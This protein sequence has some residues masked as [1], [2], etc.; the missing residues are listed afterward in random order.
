MSFISTE[1]YKNVSSIKF[2]LCSPEYIHS[3]S[4]VGITEIGLYKNKV[5]KKNGCNDLRMGT[6][7]RSLVCATCNQSS[8]NCPGH[9]G[10]I[11]FCEPI[12]NP[13]QVK[14]VFKV[15]RSVCFW[16]SSLLVDENKRPG[17][18]CN[19]R[20]RKILTVMSNMGKTVKV[21]PVCS[22][23]QPDYVRKVY[24]ITHSFPQPDTAFESPEEKNKASEPLTTK[25]IRD[26]LRNIKDEDIK[27]IGMCP[28]NS[29]PEWMV[30]T[31]ML[32]PPPCIRPSVLVSAGTQTRGEDF[33]T[34]KLQ[35]IVKFNRAI[36]RLKKSGGNTTNSVDALQSQVAMYLDKDINMNRPR[37][38]SM[39]S[40]RRNNRNNVTRSL[41][42]RLKGK[43]GR[44][45]G[46]CMGKRQNYSSRTVITPDAC[47]DID[48]LG[49]PKCIALK[50]TI[51]VRVNKLNITQMTT[52]VRI[53][54]DSLAGALK[55]EGIRLRKHLPP[56]TVNLAYCNWDRRQSLVLEPGMVVHRF[57]N[58]ED[59]V[60]FN[61]QPTLHKESMIGHRVKIVKG[62]SFLLPV[63]DTTPY[64]A[65]FDG[66]EMN[67]FT[68]QTIE[69]MSEIKNLMGIEHQMIGLKT[70]RPA[71]GCVQ[72]TVIGLYLMCRPGTFVSEPNFMSLSMNCRYSDGILPKPAILKPKRL[73]TG[74]Q[75][76]SLAIPNNVNM[77]G[78]KMANTLGSECL[79]NQDAS[80]TAFI[81]N[82]CIVYGAVTKTVSG[83]S[84]GGLVHV[85][86]RQHGNKRAMNLVSDLQRLATRW[87]LVRGCSVGIDDCMPSIECENKVKQHLQ[88]LVDISHNHLSNDQEID[89]VQTLQSALSDSGSIVSSSI[90][91]NNNLSNLIKSGSKGS[92]VNLA[93][94]IGCVGHQTNTEILGAD[95]RNS[96]NSNNTAKL[97]G[98]CQSSFFHGLD[99]IE[100]FMHTTSGR[101]GLID[102][103]VKTSSTGYVQR[104]IIKSMEPIS[105]A[106]DRSVRPNQKRIL[107][108]CFGGN[109]LSCERMKPVSVW[110]LEAS[111]EKIVEKHGEED[112]LRILLLRTEI[113]RNRSVFYTNPSSK[114]L[115]AFDTKE[116]LQ[117]APGKYQE[118]TYSDDLKNCVLSLRRLFG[119]P[120]AASVHE[121]F[122]LCAF[123][124]RQGR[125]QKIPNTVFQLALEGVSCSLVDSGENIGTLSSV[126]IGEPIT[127]MTL[128]SVDYKTHLVVRFLE[129]IKGVSTSGCIGFVIDQLMAA[130]KPGQIQMYANNTAY[131]PLA[132]GTAEALTVDENGRS[133]W[134]AL[135]AVTRHPPIN[136]DGSHTLLKVT[137]ESGRSVIAT[138]AKSF[139][140]VKGG[141]LVDVAGEDLKIGDPIPV[142]NQLPISTQTSF[143]GYSL[144]VRLGL[145]I[146]VYLRDGKVTTSPMEIGLPEHFADKLADWCHCEEGKRRVPVFAFDAPTPF[147]EALLSTCVKSTFRSE[148]LVEGL[149][150]LLTR[151]G[152][153]AT[154][155]T[156]TINNS[157]VYYLEYQMDKPDLPRQQDVI[158]DPITTIE[159]VDSSHPYVYDLTVAKTRNMVTDSGLVQRDTFHQAG[160]ASACV[161]QGVPR[162]KEFMDATKKIRTPF[163]YA[164]CRIKGLRCIRDSIVERC[165]DTKVRDLSLTYRVQTEEDSSSKIARSLACVWEQLKGTDA[166]VAAPA[167][168]IVFDFKDDTGFLDAAVKLCVLYNTKLEVIPMHRT[169]KTPPR[170]YLFWKHRS[171]AP[172]PERTVA[173]TQLIARH[174]LQ[175]HIRGTP[176]ITAVF[177]SEEETFDVTLATS[178]ISSVIQIPCLNPLSVY[179]ND[180]QSTQHVFGVE[181]ALCTLQREMQK[182]L[183]YDGNQIHWK[184][185]Y[186]LAE[187]IMQRGYMCPITRHGMGKKKNGVLLRA[188]FETTADVF[189]EGACHA[190]VDNMDG[191]TESIMFANRM[192][193][194]TGAF[195]VLNVST[196]GLSD[197]ERSSQ[198]DQKSKSKRVKIDW[199]F[200]ENINTR[201][202]TMVELINRRI[203]RSS[204]EEE[205]EGDA[206]SPVF[207]WSDDEYFPPKSPEQ[208]FDTKKCLSPVRSCETDDEYF[209]PQSPSPLKI[210]DIEELAPTELS[211]NS[212]LPPQVSSCESSEEE[213]IDD[214]CFDNQEPSSINSN[215][216]EVYT[217]VSSP[218]L[219]ENNN[220]E[221]GLESPNFSMPSPVYILESQHS[222]YIAPK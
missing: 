182:V 82:G 88:K 141:K 99:P 110:E 105:V 64:N 214:L 167:P 129:P 24:S 176:G 79:T 143:N 127:Q 193:C 136:K 138:R 92:I 66:D 183:E 44:I 81:R 71:I 219:D 211:L 77:G 80:M 199:N 124:N 185:I 94:V 144:T 161:T 59:Y 209:P 181:A 159:V 119:G 184:H 30:W 74:Y 60:V 87:L 111:R 207:T 49:V 11:D 25:H 7:D 108:P 10:H 36:E 19:Y 157:T 47:M 215:E 21:C 175:T 220:A 109:G 162:F 37:G 165:V 20:K 137:T 34:I 139:L 2:G 9:F 191:V 18:K 57:L 168:F 130:A 151:L 149:S 73:Y 85:V 5:P 1:K 206:T 179:C 41:V 158:L 83:R 194:G 106:Y 145:Y 62:M 17:I 33:L 84:A 86:C 76:A 56:A 26:I 35:E 118:K 89:A 50:Q 78:H 8:L 93:Q 196:N 45:R 54:A 55:V 132:P 216:E 13:S 16:C 203:I 95:R 155:M 126:S 221:G 22:G 190:I 174:V 178:S 48:Q 180:I 63:P 213:D 4:V 51:P 43:K 131:L 101:E 212:P 103:A 31:C 150:L 173:V 98:F 107:Q 201:I 65:D 153:S 195:D 217:F 70:G 146:G 147:V 188:S 75:L 91:N 102:T 125:L 222:R 15:L 140:V 186:L 197:M 14:V 6:I 120:G 170:I 27:Q 218:K 72:D 135:E 163:C 53:G 164:N 52:R 40:A 42:G 117:N 189:N 28:V 152:G 32:V 205:G 210:S 12:I 192:P 100:V 61:R 68:P 113:T 134:E 112:G 128:N 104:R 97:L 58:D 177:V 200:F 29:R 115:C 123:S 3:L 198:I 148:A 114:L 204:S 96:Y 67:M 169:S 122:L 171:V 116:I 69:A 121:F 90:S 38:K 172:I 160:L 46:N 23:P 187:N 202:D 208:D 133:S 39:R 156:K 166:E 154:L 142:I